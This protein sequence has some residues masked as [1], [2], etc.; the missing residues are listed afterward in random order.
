MEWYRGTTQTKKS[1]E[2]LHFLTRV[3]VLYTWCTC[4]ISVL[5]HVFVLKYILEYDGTVR[6][7]T[8]V[9]T[10]VLVRISYCHGLQYWYTGTIE[11]L[12][13]CFRTRVRTRVSRPPNAPWAPKMNACVSI[14]NQWQNNFDRSLEQ[15]EISQQHH[16]PLGVPVLQYTG[17]CRYP[18][19][20]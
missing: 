7:R 2:N 4:A 13:Y 20:V 3:G 16:P 14:P 10:R 6:E 19:Y 8:H 11:I 5:I 15:L 12:K 9:R 17:M 18:G 1:S